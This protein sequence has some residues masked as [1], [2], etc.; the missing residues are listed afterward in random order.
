M[1]DP[2]VEDALERPA[3]DPAPRLVRLTLAP[4]DGV[5][6][7]APGPTSCRVAGLRPWLELL[8]DTPEPPSG[9]ALL[10]GTLRGRGD[11]YSARLVLERENGQ[12]VPLDLPVTRRGT[13]SELVHLPPDL[14]RLVLECRQGEGV[15]ELGPF[16][17]R[18]VGLGERLRRFYSRLFAVYTRQSRRR[19]KS[20]GL[21][22]A[23]ALLRPEEAY[24]LAGRFHAHAPALDYAR[25]LDLHDLLTPADR[26][27]IALDAA[28]LS[29]PCVIARGDPDVLAGQLYPARLGPDWPPEPDA[30]YLWPGPGARLAPQALYWL[31]RLVTDRPELGLVYADHDHLDARG[32]RCRPEFKPDWSPELLRA[33]NYIGPALA[34]RGALLADCGRPAGPD[35]L[36]DLLLRAAE[37]LTPDRVAHIHAPLFHLPDRPPPAGDGAVVR[38]HL[39]RCG[40]AGTVEVVGP[41]CYRVRY[42][43]PEDPPLVSVLVATRDRADILDRCLDSLWSRSSYPRLEVVVVDNQSREPRTL[44]Y[45]SAIAQRPGV[46]VL[47][48]DAPFNF[49]AINNLAV[50]AARGDA[51]CL[52][53]SDTEV[54]DPDWL[55]EMVGRLLQPEVGVVGAKLLYADGRVQHAGDVVGPCGCAWHLHGHLP[56]DAPGYC[57]RAVLA[58]ELSAVTGACLLTWR[59]LY[60]SLG[61]LDAANLPVTFNDVDYCLRVRQTGRRVLFTPHARLYHLESASRGPDDTKAKR[62]RSRREADYMRRRWKEVM[63]HDPYYNPN[64]SYARADFS[65]NCAPLVRRPWRD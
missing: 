4:L 8:W 47:P 6:R 24:R 45:L 31:A 65:L 61:G 30:W 15:F 23:T 25:W 57:H 1:T 22:L 16:T 64:L 40:Q 33:T 5:D 11:R 63:R 42:A 39:A 34:L 56:A 19:R 7:L 53:N 10:R 3:S 35:G 52:L 59:D 43:L 17:L 60:R 28:R 55:E 36:H 32:R 41:G 14:A 18:L 2:A 27:A 37:R 62:E 51:V 29:V 13:V 44:D 21:R 50:E 26:A 20:V 9:W 46:T 54:I 49:A 12:A 58:Q 38:D 48:Y